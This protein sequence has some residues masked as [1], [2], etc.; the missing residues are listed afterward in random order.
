MSFSVSM[1]WVIVV[2]CSWCMPSEWSLDTVCLFCIVVVVVVVVVVQR[3]HS[4][5]PASCFRPKKT[6]HGL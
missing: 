3:K 6:C 1:I 5:T 2:L 4:Q